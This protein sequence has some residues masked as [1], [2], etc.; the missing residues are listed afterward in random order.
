MRQFTEAL[1]AT[2]AREHRGPVEFYL[3]ALDFDRIGGRE[4]SEPLADYYEDKYR[5]FGVDV[6]VPV[7]G[8]ALTFAVEHLRSALPEVPIVFA[9]CARP[10]TDPALLPANVTGRIAP[11]SRF[12]PT[13]EMARR[14]QPDAEQVVVIGGAGASDTLSVL[15]AVRAVKESGSRLPVTVF[16]GLSLDA[17]LPALRKLP[18][19]SIVLFANYRKDAQGRA[20]EPLDIIGSLAHAAQ[21]PMYAQ[22]ETYVGEGVVGG[23]VVG[24]DD[25]GAHTG[26]LVA[27]VLHRRAGERLPPVE[28]IAH[29]FIAD[30][31]QLRRFSLSESALPVGT[32]LRF[33]EL[34]PWER[35]RDVALVTFGVLVAES[36]LVGA[37]L[38]ERRRRRRA[39]ALTDAQQRR[40]D[41]TR[42]QVAHMGRVAL[43]GELAAAIA[44][45]LR[46]PLAA[47]RANAETGVRLVSRRSGALSTEERELCREIFGA[48]A[49]DD[50]LAADIVTR[51]RALV[52]RESLPEQ[53][54]RLNEV[55]LDS[56]R[57]L[58]HEARARKAELSL[59]LAASLPAVS[60]D[61]VQLQQVVLNLVANALDASAASASSRVVVS[62][63][64]RGDTVEISVS[65]NGR[66]L[67][68]D[69][70]HR[71]F[72][73]FF[74]TKPEGLGLGLAIVKSTV[75][76]HRGTVWAEN[77]VRGGAV[78]SVVLP[79]MPGRPVVAP[80][81][82]LAA[83]AATSLVT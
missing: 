12:T 65:D 37:L 60:G 81:L 32:R 56:V 17:L 6:V 2:I 79:A 31:R 10:Q 69:V 28:T 67:T 51:I 53:P 39:Q 38:I 22:L 82:V 77:D 30:W 45:E 71:L 41:E 24:L 68:D 42:R 57:L 74:T 50:A 64:D 70:R 13:L 49:D 76:R 15:A 4:N 7:G 18:R 62:T 83:E 63:F 61:P 25:E 8:R 33:R 48:I 44:H 47:I 54:V 3:E 21:A 26:R 27:R 59:S 9:L 36:V 1:R 29:S 66:G 43:V 20:F 16:Q 73:S 23:S 40:I 11:P 80:E 78:F 5:D 35:Y 34:S 46:Q 72:E 52:R 14:L 19:N 75:E 58:R 55:C